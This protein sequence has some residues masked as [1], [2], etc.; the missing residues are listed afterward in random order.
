MV[1]CYVLTVT[2]WLNIHVDIL[3]RTKTRFIGNSPT[4]ESGVKPRVVPSL[5]KCQPPV[6]LSIPE[7]S[8]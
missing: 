1:S 8:G 5:F 4:T 2:K 3:R 7:Y 6:A